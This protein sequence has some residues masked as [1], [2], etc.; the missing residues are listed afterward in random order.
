[1]RSFPRRS[2]ADQRMRRVSVARILQARNSFEPPLLNSNKLLAECDL[3]WKRQACAPP[4]GTGETN[5]IMISYTGRLTLESEHVTS[6]RILETRKPLLLLVPRIPRW[7]CLLWDGQLENIK[8]TQFITA[9]VRDFVLARLEQP[10][11]ERVVSSL[12]ALAEVI[13]GQ[14]EEATDLLG[15]EV[16]V[17]NTAG[18]YAAATELYGGQMN[19]L[20]T[21]AEYDHSSLSALHKAL[22]LK[23]DVQS[24]FDLMQKF[25]KPPIGARKVLKIHVNLVKLPEGNAWPQVR[26]E[27]GITLTNTMRDMTFANLTAQV[28]DKE[29]VPGFYA[30]W[31]RERIFVVAYSPDD[32]RNAC[33]KASILQTFAQETVISYMKLALEENTATREWAQ[34]IIVCEIKNTNELS[35]QI[36]TD[37]I[38]LQKRGR[39]T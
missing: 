7:I 38:A 29:K 15:K 35:E 19:P 1:M 24:L 16:V 17:Y 32:H 30:I 11:E 26:V 6:L 12:R 37:L 14:D 31:W 27:L 8:S 2:V 28:I 10:V 25:A 20:Y 36:A 23:M 18:L 22:P 39:K 5:F 21:G 4:P 33:P 3:C 9:L 34:K 13:S